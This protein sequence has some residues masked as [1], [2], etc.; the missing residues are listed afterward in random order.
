MTE[1]V[2][3]TREQI[4][5]ERLRDLTNK[6][7]AD[8]DL[9]PRVQAFAKQMYPDAKTD[10]D[11][12]NPYLDP[13]REENAKL[14]EKIAKME[15]A[16]AAREAEAEKKAGET[17]FKDMLDKVRRDYSLT[18]EGLDKVVQRMKDAGAYDAEAAAAWVARQTPPP[19]SPGPTWAPQHLN[20]FG[21]RDKDESMAQLHRDPQG[22]MDAQLSEFVKD[23]DRYVAETYRQ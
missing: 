20:L 21:S 3:K 17:S 22:Y 2:V 19:A 1:P 16:Q 5:D 9:G 6:L 23:P 13:I 12:V 14:A 11:V 8:K 10:V 18:D 7:W 15:A 4:A